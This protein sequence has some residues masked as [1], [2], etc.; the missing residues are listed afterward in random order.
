[1]RSLLN[2]AQK[3]QGV[4]IGK[5]LFIETESFILVGKYD[6]TM[7]EGSDR[8]SMSAITD[9]QKVLFYLQGTNKICI[10]EGDRFTNNPF[11][12]KVDPLI[13]KIRGDGQ[14]GRK[15][16]GSKQT[17]RH[18]K[19]IETRVGNISEHHSVSNSQ[20]ALK[21]LRELIRK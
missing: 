10:W 6:G 18:L 12:E 8:L 14:A 1:M 19:S 2:L 11:I 21:F 17:E 5:I 9:V 20:N 3:K 4:Q 13:L 16:R 7:F 15:K